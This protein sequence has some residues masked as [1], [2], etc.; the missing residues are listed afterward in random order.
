MTATAS[1]MNSVPEALMGL[2]VSI[3]DLEQ[4]LISLFDRIGPVLGSSDAENGEPSDKIA[5]PVMITERILRA[6]RRIHT[7][8]RAVRMTANRVEL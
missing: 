2:D 3:E 5:H 1:K 6:Q 8:T 4:A 7:F